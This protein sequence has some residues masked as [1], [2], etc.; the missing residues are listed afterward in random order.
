MPERHAA[1]PHLRCRT[2]G[3]E[4]SGAAEE[5]KAACIARRARSFGEYRIRAEILWEPVVGAEEDAVGADDGRNDRL[6]DRRG[7]P[8]AP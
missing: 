8:G 2:D 4:D 1:G 3:G 6:G 5:P 7:I